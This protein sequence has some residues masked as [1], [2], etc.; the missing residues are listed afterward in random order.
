[1]PGSAP[2]HYKLIFQVPTGKVLG[3]QAISKGDAP[4]RV[5]IAATLMKF[6]GTVYDLRDLELCYAPP[7]S[8]PKDAG[9]QAGL[10]ACNLLEG[11]FR[12]VRVQEVRGLVEAGACIIDVREEAEYARSHIKTAVNIP[13]SQLRRRLEEIPRD[14]PVYLHC[15]SAQRS[16]NACRCL[17]GHGFSNVY[18]IS[19]SFLGLCLFEYF[20]DVTQGRE[21][22]VTGYNF[23]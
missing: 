22:I 5:D 12:Q 19:G 16:Y 21:P 15:R 17:Q 9:N 23:Q 18:N 3:V 10:V 2:L 7:F 4:K 11:A 1:M 13:L 6:G 20:N 14:R 8:N